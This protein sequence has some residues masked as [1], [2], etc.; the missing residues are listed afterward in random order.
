MLED[1]S[2]PWS[3][4]DLDE[5]DEEEDTQQG[6][7]LTFQVGREH[8]A[9][10]I[11]HVTEIIRLQ[12]ITGVPDMPEFLR[13]V[14]NL[15]GRVIPVV[16]VRLRFRL[17][18]QE[19]G[20]RTCIIVVDV[21]EKAVGLVV[22][23]VDEVLSIPPDQIEPPPPSAGGGRYIQGLGKVGEEVKILLDLERLLK[24]EEWEILCQATQAQA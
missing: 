7:F 8:Y 13:G 23:R 5:D 17:P 24:R 21:E 3:A 15:R 18:F 22:D 20:E 2:R 14:I 6:R 11:S 16:D 10:A 12:K 1:K 19:Y 9:I 4:G